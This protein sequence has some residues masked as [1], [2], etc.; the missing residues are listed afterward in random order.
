M[1]F[2]ICA[3]DSQPLVHI[4]KPKGITGTLQTAQYI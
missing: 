4:L 2:T 1:N 3:G